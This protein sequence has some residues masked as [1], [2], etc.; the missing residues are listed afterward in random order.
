MFLKR[1]DR[2]KNFTV[3]VTSVRFEPG[4]GTDFVPY[5]ICRQELKKRDV[6]FKLRPATPHYNHVSPPAM[7]GRRTRNLAIL[8]IAYLRKLCCGLPGSFI[9][10]GT[11]GGAGRSLKAG[12]G[13]GAESDRLFRTEYKSVRRSMVPG[14][15]SIDYFFGSFNF[16]RRL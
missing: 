6:L 14:R 11:E 12:G 4:T 10:T 3:H 13:C 16:L 2:S 5:R 1:F 9:N 8:I 7:Y 15:Y